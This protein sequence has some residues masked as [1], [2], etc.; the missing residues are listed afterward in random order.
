MNAPESRYF[1]ADEVSLHNKGSDCWVSYFGKVYDLTPLIQH[2]EG[3]LAQPIIDA[4]GSDIS[5]WFSEDTGAPKRCID[6]VSNLDAVWCPFG[7]YIHV[8]PIYPDASWKTNLGTASVS[9]WWED[10]K[11]FIGELT[12]NSRQIGVQN[13]LTKQLDFINVADEESM[14]EILTR[15]LPHNF[16]ASSYTWKRLGKPLDME[17]TLAE[18]GVPDDRKELER[19]QIDPDEHTPVIQLYFNDD[20]TV[21]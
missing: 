14:N 4:A 7:R 17:K 13:M 16:H 21:A 8:P 1:T 15:Y 5:H 10:D 3:P 12:A 20:L 19:L 2:H 18:N 9:Q 11:Y 6:P